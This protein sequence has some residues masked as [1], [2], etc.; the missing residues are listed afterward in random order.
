MAVLL[1]VLS[2]SLLPYALFL[3]FIFYLMFI[4]FRIL[5][6]IMLTGWI[7]PPVSPIKGNPTKAFQDYFTGV[8]YFK[9][10]N[11]PLAN[12]Y[13]HSAHAN[14]PNNFS[15]CLSYSLTQGKLNRLKE[16]DTHSGHSSCCQDWPG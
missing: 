4:G 15:F 3:N 5:L 14:I 9:E 16:A 7:N 13:F 6:L 10:G 1:L 11:I 8:N 12:Q 2:L